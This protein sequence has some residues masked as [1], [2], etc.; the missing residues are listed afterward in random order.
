MQNHI[1]AETCFRCCFPTIKISVTSIVDEN[2]KLHG[3]KIETSNENATPLHACLS[4]TS[5][6]IEFH[7]VYSFSSLSIFSNIE[8]MKVGVILMQNRIQAEN[9]F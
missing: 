9:L 3:T 7:A 4:T 1:Q 5:R 6:P 2:N 8:D